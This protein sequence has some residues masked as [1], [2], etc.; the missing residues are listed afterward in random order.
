MTERKRETTFRTSKGGVVYV[1]APEVYLS[2]GVAP[3]RTPVIHNVT[4][5]GADT[6]YSQALPEGTKKFTLKE[7]NVKPFRFA[8][9]T[10][11]VAGPTE[12]YV[13]VQELMAYWDDSLETED[14]TLYFASTVAGRVI[15]I[16][17]WT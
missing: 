3:G 4:L 1:E 6:E 9:E 5:T 16:V 8:F 13:Q 14:V 10:G 2:P 17:V 7:R 11:R 12:P 15:E